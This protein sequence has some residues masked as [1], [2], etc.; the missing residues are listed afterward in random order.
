M[1]LLH[2][3]IRIDETSEGF[4]VESKAAVVDALLISVLVFRGLLANLCHW[5]TRCTCIAR[6][7]RD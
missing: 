2:E 7:L 3:N 5:L 1:K 6:S 4:G